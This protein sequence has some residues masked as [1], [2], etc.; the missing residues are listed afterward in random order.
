MIRAAC[1][2]VML[3]AASP[4]AAQGFNGVWQG[5]LTCDAVEGIT[6]VPLDAPFTIR[7]EGAV[8]KYE[9]PV[10]S[11]SGARTGAWER[12][13]GRVG[14]DGALLLQGGSS[15]RGFH[16]R[17]RYEGRLGADSVARFTGAQDWMLADRDFTRPC[18]VEVRR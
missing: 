15:G 11:A 17:A 5:R 3:C 1:L 13:E 8:A 7:V 4:L 18:A 16:Y 14:A 2:A 6:Q 12:G 10:L 9:R